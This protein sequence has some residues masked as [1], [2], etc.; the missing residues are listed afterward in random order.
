MLLA[1]R[2]CSLQAATPGMQGLNMVI[3]LILAHG[4]CDS[5]QDVTC[6]VKFKTLHFRLGLHTSLIANRD[7]CRRLKFARHVVPLACV[8]LGFRL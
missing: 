7:S 4:R 8:H 6:F 1:S 3:D 2:G 5:F